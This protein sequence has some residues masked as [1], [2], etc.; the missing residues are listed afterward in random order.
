MSSWN[1]VIPGRWGGVE[2]WRLGCRVVSKCKERSERSRRTD[3]WGSVGQ[4]KN[5]DEKKKT[6]DY[7]ADAAICE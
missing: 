1:V 3:G 2:V 5:G 7:E 6:I 4:R